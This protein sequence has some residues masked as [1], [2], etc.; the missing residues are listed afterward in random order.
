ME[1]V[2]I[3][4][5]EISNTDNSIIS[6][7]CSL[8]IDYQNRDSYIKLNNNSLERPVGLPSDVNINDVLYKILKSEK[9]IRLSETEMN[10]LLGL[11]D[12]ETV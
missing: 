4:L 5:W 1:T 9:Y 2:L 8:H 12:I 7:G 6:D 3:Q 10:N 11:K